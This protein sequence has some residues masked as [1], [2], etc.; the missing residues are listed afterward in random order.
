[1][2]ARL[3][4]AAVA[5]GLLVA[6]DD[7][8]ADDPVKADLKKLE[9][10]WVVEKLEAA[11]PAPEE[12]KKATLTF[13]G[14]KLT[15]KSAGGEEMRQTVRLDPKKNPKEM[16]FVPEKKEPNAAPGLAIY[17]LDGDTLTLALGPPD[18]RPTKFEPP[19]NGFLLVLKRKK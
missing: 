8:K 12:L 7:P 15:M 11:G 16:N 4:V 1:M 18:K 13:A 14:D 3:V 2:L 6:A 10:T 9:G 17:K 19:E 5:V